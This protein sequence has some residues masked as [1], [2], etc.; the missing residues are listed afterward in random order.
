MDKKRVIIIGAGFGGLFTARKLLKRDDLDITVVDRNNFHTFTPLIYQVATA[1]L[2]ASDVA[3]PVRSVFRK[4]DNVR[5]VLGEVTDIDTDTKCIK[6]RNE[7]KVR[8][9]GYDYL[10]VAAGSVASYFG[11]DDYRKFAYELNDVPSALEIRNH[12]LRLFERATW[13]D[14]PEQREAMLTI[15]VVGGG[16][17]GLETAGALYELYNHVLDREY[18]GDDLSARVLLVE[19]KDHLLAPY[20]AGLQK[21]AKK[22]VE[23]LGVEVVLNA[24][25]EDIDAHSV[26]LSDGTVIPTYTVIWAAG[27]KA[28]PLAEM[29]GVNLA[30]AGRIPVERT[31]QLPDTDGVYI[32]GDIAHLEDKHGNPYPMQIAVAQQQARLAAKNI[33]AELD[34][35]ALQDFTYFDKGMMATIG[36][37][38]A[39]AFLFN[40]VP[41][42]GPLAW[43]AWL[44]LHLVTLMGFRNRVAVFINWVW[45]YFTYDRSVRIILDEEDGLA[46]S[47]GE[48]EAVE[49]ARQAVPTGASHAAVSSNGQ[50]ADSA[51]T[52]AESEQDSRAIA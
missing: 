28:N 39:V 7:D 22:Q 9:V 50:H 23:S 15:V 30:R 19:G 17:T 51:A 27:V 35:K 5:F 47:E 49:K 2:D 48:Q 42:T 52:D 18:G 25:V 11:N 33:K 6:I 1:A 45:N 20:P 44:G 24:F 4:N 26:S 37:T 34:G 16:P 32:V 29:L 10:I 21:S 3:Y 13:T 12:V 8:T 36:R 14:D 40:R 43:L 41:M 31:L 38:R 46:L